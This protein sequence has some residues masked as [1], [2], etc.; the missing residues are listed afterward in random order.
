MKQYDKR[1]SLCH[2]QNR[3]FVYFAGW[4]HPINPC[5]PMVMHAYI[6]KNKLVVFSFRFQLFAFNRAD[7]ACIAACSGFCLAA[8]V[9]AWQGPWWP[10]RPHRRVH[11]PCRGRVRPVDKALNNNNNNN[12]N[13]VLDISN[14]NL[15]QHGAIY[16]FAVGRW[17]NCARGKFVKKL[18]ATQSCNR[19]YLSVAGVRC[20]CHL[21]ADC[22]HGW[23]RGKMSTPQKLSIILF[24]FTRILF[25]LSIV[26]DMSK[27]SRVLTGQQMSNFRYS[28]ETSWALR[29]VCEFFPNLWICRHFVQL[30][31]SQNWGSKFYQ[32]KT[33]FCAEDL[34]V[35][36]GPP[37]QE[38]LVPWQKGNLESEMA[39]S[40][41]CRH[42]HG[43]FVSFL[44]KKNWF[45]TMAMKGMKD[46]VIQC[47]SIVGFFWHVKAVF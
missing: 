1:I 42:R 46:I 29:D 15:V 44:S 3:P 31:M 41:I 38:I 20:W 27:K 10:A 8:A 9:S 33:T 21:H 19:T 25:V 32:G 4:R 7:H 43:D 12:N 14:I 2:S 39:K 28:K 22:I 16:R 18:H 26:S 17:F 13:H 23:G 36:L 30:D 40:Y 34:M 11:D 5:V 24:T 6:V 37:P 47:D 45:E 35:Q